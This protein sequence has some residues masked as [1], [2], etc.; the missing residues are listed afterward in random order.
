MP[1]QLQRAGLA[2]ELPYYIS[3]EGLRGK[4]EVSDCTT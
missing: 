1:L 4:H 3:F 2:A